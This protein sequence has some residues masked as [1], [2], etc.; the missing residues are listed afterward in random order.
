MLP[1]SN[2][3]KFKVKWD[4]ETGV[5]FKSH[6]EY[7]KNF[8]D[9]FYEQVKI[10]IDKNQQKEKNNFSAKENELLQEVLDHVAFC[11]LTFS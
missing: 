6:P 4:K 11:N 8:G 7:I 9:T 5:S 3:F 1:E 10:L 2:I